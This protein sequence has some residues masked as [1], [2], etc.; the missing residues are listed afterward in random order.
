M[1][2]VLVTGGAGFIGSHVLA[3]L[4]ARGFA[5]TSIDNY[6]NSS[7]ES[8]E[9]VRRITGA[10][11]RAFQADIRDRPTVAE[12]VAA[13]KFDS[14]IHCAGL[15]AVGESVEQPLEYYENNVGGTICLL[16]VLQEAGVRQFVF[17][18]SATVYGP[19]EAMPLDE[20]A[21]VQPQSPYGH[22]KL[23]IERI[24]ADVAA[25][26]RS[27]RIANLRY[28]NPV[29]AHESGLI[30]EDPADVPNNLMPF[31]CQVAA[32]RRKALQVFGDDYP[33]RD[34]TGVRDYIHVMDLAEAH[35][36]A[37]EHMQRAA[38][39]VVTVNLGTGRGYSVL[40]LVE[41]FE[42]VNGVRV[43][44]EIVARR[45]GDVATCYAHP[46]LAEETLG[47]KARR[48]LDDMCRDAWRW[49][50]MNPNGYRLVAAS[51]RRPL[52]V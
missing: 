40:E 25:H 12:I 19:S 44:R 42:R 51:P 35:L 45:P 41:A 46:G 49:Q 48:G 27:W 23:M 34:G 36:A 11:I 33:T 10:G 8:I 16:R 37:L 1:K 18:S 4:A 29:G 32:G 7:P 17:S 3:V 5:C 52:E 9:R 6:S 28:F 50:S 21:P 15:K 38:S 20:S 43:N 13:E 24:L 26:D 47:W 22:T 31:V 2:S 39:H 14:V 30:G